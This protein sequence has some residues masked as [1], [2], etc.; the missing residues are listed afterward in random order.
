MSRDAAGRP[1]T[2]GGGSVNINERKLAELA[3]AA[4]EK[5]QRALLDTFPFNVWLKDGE[6][7]FLAVNSRFAESFGW[8]SSES[9]VG[10]TDFDITDEALAHGYRAEDKAVIASGQPRNVEEIVEVRGVRQWHETY[11]SP[12]RL[13]G[14]IIGTVGFSRD[15]SE[16]RQL[17]SQLVER[18]ALM[19]TLVHAIPDLFWLKN[20]E[21]EYLACNQRFEQFTGAKEADL[22]G[23]TDYDLVDKEL[24]DLFRENEKKAMAQSRLDRTGS[25]FVVDYLI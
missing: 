8:P 13:G 18:E 2:A 10:K 19:R 20:P 12:V 1:L 11:K 22:V 23:K 5:Y 7:R 3:L 14:K 4:R 24:A 16:R 25:L 21:G 9:L 17:L 6:S 15:I